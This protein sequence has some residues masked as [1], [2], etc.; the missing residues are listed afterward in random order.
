ML[1]HGSAIYA[2]CMTRTARC[3]VSL[4]IVVAVAVPVLGSP[5]RDSFPLSTYPM[6]AGNREP[7]MSFISARGLTP[8]G[9]QVRLSIGEQGAT[10]DPLIAESRFRRAHATGTLEPLCGDIS[11]RVQTERGSDQ[12]ATVEII[13]QVFDLGAHDDG[14]AR[15]QTTTVL[16]SCEVPE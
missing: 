10:D 7:V 16:I 3:L 5:F 1:L 4:A 9:D 15:P 8:S 6:Y 2:C 14:T 12:V 11:A 13:E